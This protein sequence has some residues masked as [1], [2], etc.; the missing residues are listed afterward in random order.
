MPFSQIFKRF[1]EGSPASVM[2]QAILDKSFSR[3]R[4]ITFSRVMHDASIRGSCCFR[5]SSS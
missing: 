1:V 5:W 2:V 4:S 3:T